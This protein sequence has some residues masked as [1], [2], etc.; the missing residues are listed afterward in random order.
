M[1]RGV[2][3]HPHIE[4]PERK[5]PVLV[6]LLELPLPDVVQR[7]VPKRVLLR[8]VVDDRLEQVGAEKVRVAPDRLVQPV[9]RRLGDAAAQA[10]PRGSALS[11]RA[12]S[13]GCNTG[14]R[15]SSTCGREG[16]GRSPRASPGRSRGTRRSARDVVLR[17]RREAGVGV[18]RRKG[19]VEDQGGRRADDADRVVAHEPL[20]MEHGK[21]QAQ[22]PSP[23]PAPRR[24]PPPS[25]P[26]GRR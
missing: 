20:V 16:T 18:L 17:H 6:R 3:V 14:A 8:R 23:S 19:V 2:V 21:G 26:G 11:G 9:D 1:V 7:G 10:R 12:A 25:S 4:V 13:R 24:N 22:L 5:D 15:S